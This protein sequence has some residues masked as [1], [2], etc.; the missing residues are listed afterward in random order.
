MAL[1]PKQEMFVKEYLIDLNAT[2]AAI[3]AGYSIKTAEVI[4][5]ENLNKPHIAET[6]QEAMAKRSLRTEI[7]AD[8]V[9][10][11]LAKIGFGNIQRCYTP[12][13]RLIPI[14]EMDADVSATITEV[15]EKFVSKSEED[16][17]VL[18]R[19]YKVADKRAALVDLGR[20]L[21]LFTDKSETELSGGL[22]IN[23]Q[24]FSGNK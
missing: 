1:R 4:G 2:Q 16:D 9:L 14:H 17:V 18:E 15:T 7:T 21:K 5:Y 23:I 20:H 19:K 11:E 6:I 24:K 22:T 12:E 3:R 8:N 13:G 10:R